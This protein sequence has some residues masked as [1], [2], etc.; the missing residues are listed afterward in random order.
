MTT[1]AQTVHSITVGS[2]VYI[3]RLINAT[4]AVTFDQAVHPIGGYPW[5][6]KRNIVNFFGEH[7][8]SK[9]M[10]AWMNTVRSAR[11]HN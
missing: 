9:A 7:A 10:V 5:Q 8:S 11:H 3:V 1:T 4:Q 6:M 2:R